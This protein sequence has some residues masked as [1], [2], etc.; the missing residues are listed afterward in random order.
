MAEALGRWKTMLEEGLTPRDL[1]SG[2]IRQLFIEGRIGMR[3]DGPW[4][5]GVMRNAEPVWTMDEVL[6]ELEQAA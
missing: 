1:A 3:V 2:D 6:H 4:L 5:Y